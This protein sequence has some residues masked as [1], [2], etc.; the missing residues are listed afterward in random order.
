[1]DRN[2]V[3]VDFHDSRFLIGN[4]N[5][6]IGLACFSTILKNLTIEKNQV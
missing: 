3:S 6:L 2:F 5:N 1:M 4:L